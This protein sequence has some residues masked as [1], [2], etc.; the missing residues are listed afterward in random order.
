MCVSHT[1]YL[2]HGNS[3]DEARGR[4]KHKRDRNIVVRNLEE[5]NVG[6]KEKSFKRGLISVKD[7]T[8]Q[9]PEGCESHYHRLD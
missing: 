6:T 8:I 2:A 4:S 7:L 5:R 3:K 9:L 1:V